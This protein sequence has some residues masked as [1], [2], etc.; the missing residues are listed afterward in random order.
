MAKE[1][2][3]NKIV[4]CT[5]IQASINWNK[6][7]GRHNTPI[8]TFREWQKAAR[9]ESKTFKVRSVQHVDGGT[10]FVTFEP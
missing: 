4:D 3:D 10:L 8:E 7:E 5:Y 1:I 2:N 9:K 6:K